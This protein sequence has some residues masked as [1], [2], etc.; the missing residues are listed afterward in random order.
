M[1]L[2]E[3][4]FVE[5]FVQRDRRERTLLCLA[6]LRKRPKFLEWL[7]DHADHILM[8][9]CIRGIKPNEQHP[10]PIYAILRRLGA[11]DSCHLI[12]EHRDFDGKEMDLLAAL[13]EII[14][15]GDGMGTVISCLP[16]RLGYLE[17]E[18]KERYILQK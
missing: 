3:Q 4:A 8:P 2:H 16:G 13:K 6:N 5:S 10:D 7:M 1:N 12:S 11:P 18:W 15:N 14:G 17:G 9:E